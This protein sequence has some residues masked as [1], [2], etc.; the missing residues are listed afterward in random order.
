[1]AGR[2][3]GQVDGIP[4]FCSRLHRL[5]NNASFCS[6]VNGRRRAMPGMT[7]TRENVS[8]IGVTPGLCLGPQAAPVSG[9]NGAVQ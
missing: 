9:R 4:G 3:R 2:F 5:G 7:S 1:M 6:V 8:D